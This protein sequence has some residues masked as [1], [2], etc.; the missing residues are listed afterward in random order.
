M[1][2]KQTSL[3]VLIIGGGIAGL[4][5]AAYLQKASS[6]PRSIRSFTS[7]VYEAHSSSE[8]SDGPG[9][10]GFAPNGIAAYAPL[11]IADDIVKVSGVNESMIF[12]TEKGS[13]L[14]RWRIDKAEYEYPMVC[15]LRSDQTIGY[16]Y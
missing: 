4:S 7:T 14:G 9:G 5:L 11:G 16:S 10:F 3:H 1:S 15:I 13:I 12:L 6:D 2:Q 8:A